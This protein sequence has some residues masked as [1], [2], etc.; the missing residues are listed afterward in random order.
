MAPR[1]VF[2]SSPPPPPLWN[3]KRSYSLINI[4]IHTPT[5]YSLLLLV[6]LRIKWYIGDAPFERPSYFPEP[7]M[8]KYFILFT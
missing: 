4:N 3:S 8:N 2:E 6:S 5:P 1:S 7:E